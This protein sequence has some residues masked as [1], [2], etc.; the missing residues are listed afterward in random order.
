MT[1]RDPLDTLDSRLNAVKRRITEG[2][3]ARADKLDAVAQRIATGDPAAVVEARRIAHRIRGHARD[4]R[5]SR[6]ASR[7]EATH[8]GVE[9]EEILR[10]IAALSKAAR[11]AAK[12]SSNTPWPPPPVVD[13]LSRILVVD[14]DPNIRHLVSLALARMGGYKVVVAASAEEAEALCEA[15]TFDLAIIDARMPNVDGVAFARRM[16]AAHAPIRIVVHSAADP[17][18]AGASEHEVDGWWRKPMTSQQLIDATRQVLAT[19]S[20]EPG[21]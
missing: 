1:Q 10:L 2:F 16:R 3:A 19:S 9:R 14:D 4:P 11:T 5:V 12:Q 21:V 20:T 6:A 13:T 7:L 17:G 8:D 15:R 18:E